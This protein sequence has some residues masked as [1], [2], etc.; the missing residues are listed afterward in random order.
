MTSALADRVFQA[1]GDRRCV[2]AL[3]GGA[4]SAVLLASAVEA[5]G[6]DRVRGVFV[7]HGLEG[8]DDLRSAVGALSEHLRV[9][10]ATVDAVVHDGPDL[11]ARARAARYQSLLG[12]LEADEV[13]CTAHTHDDQAETVL[14]RLMRGSGSTG[15]SGIPRLRHPFV[16][17]FLDVSRAELR[18]VADEGGLPF[19]DDPANEDPRFL[20]S[21]VRSELIPLIEDEYAPSFRD[22]LVRTARLAAHD[23]LALQTVSN[24][25]PIRVTEDEV[26]IP[27]APL[28][29]A[30]LAVAG[31]SVRLALGVFHDP[32]RGSY[33]DVAAVLDTA[34]DGVTRTL[35]G[36]ISCVRENAEVVLVRKQAHAPM[37]PVVVTVSSPFVWCGRNYSTDLSMAPSLRTTSGRRTSLRVLRDDERLEIRGVLDGDRIDIDNGTTPVVEVLRAAGVPAR[38]RPFWT[39]ITIG[40]KIAALHGIKVAPWARPIGGEYAVIIEREDAL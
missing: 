4:D 28:L 9:S 13:C 3:G 23:D 35:S 36:D 39:V 8:S 1:V 15:V 17:P 7:Y 25:I 21:R 11:E 18:L 26:A 19:F 32:Y 22:N 31:R 16:R 37:E 10:L 12:E 40:A 38:L 6:G 2:V 14:M 33:D 27:T 5:L 24:D 30:P 34:A 29:T 20:R